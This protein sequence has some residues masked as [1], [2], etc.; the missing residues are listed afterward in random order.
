MEE[1]ESQPFPSP[2]FLL[3]IPL[4]S[5]REV[6]RIEVFLDLWGAAYGKCHLPGERC[7]KAGSF[8]PWWVLGVFRQ[9]P[10]DPLWEASLGVVLHVGD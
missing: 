3:W 1:E 9:Q 5:G 8:P 2:G 10:W 7:S 4:D 6:L